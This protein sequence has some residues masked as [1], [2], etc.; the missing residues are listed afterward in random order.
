MRFLLPILA[1]S[2]A[3]RFA[4]VFRFFFR[5]RDH[6]RSLGFCRTGLVDGGRIRAARVVRLFGALL[7]LC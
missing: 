4:V 7:G 6:L 3:I 5:V 2:L 1:P